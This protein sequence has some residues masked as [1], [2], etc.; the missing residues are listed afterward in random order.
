[1]SKERFRAIDAAKGVGIILVILG[2]TITQ[3]EMDAKWIRILHCL[4]YS[5][6]MPLFFL[7]SGFV[8]TK[9][10]KLKT[11][12]DRLKYIK[13]RALRLLVPYFV[14]GLIYIPVKLKLDEYAVVKFHLKDSFKLLIGENPDLSL[15]FLYILFVVSSLC[16]LFLNEGNFNSFLVG[17]AALGAASW[18]VNIPVRTPK[19]LFFFLA[20]MWLRKRFDR[21]RAEGDGYLFRNKGTAAVLAL[22]IFLV[23]NRI[24]FRTSISILIFGTSVCGIYLTL[25][26]SENLCRVFG[27]SRITKAL[28]LSGAYSMDIYILHE[29]VMTAVKILTWNIPGL[30]NLVCLTL[31]FLSALLIPLPLSKYVIRKIPGLKS[32]FLGVWKKS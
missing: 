17:A 31:I 23:L 19:Y 8:A 2:H 1:M 30:G 4:I 27:N 3:M 6:H 11:F 32:L 14:I 20:G 13:E 16:A 9:I 29:P 5:F 24:Y 28:E 26:F 22:I 12:Q 10:L 7:L 15:W 25:W 21:A 18:F